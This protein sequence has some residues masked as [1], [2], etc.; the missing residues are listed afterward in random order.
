MCFRLLLGCFCAL[1][2]CA[3]E[4]ALLQATNTG[5]F[6]QIISQAKSKVY[7]TVVFIMCVR[8]N[9]EGGK[10]TTS[11]VAG[12][13]VL[14]SEKGEVL[15]NWHVVDKAIEI[16][17]LLH[18]ERSMTAKVLG[19][20]RDTDVALLQ[21]NLPANGPSLPYAKFGNSTL[22]TE[23]DFVLAM[24]A[25]WGLARSVSLGIVSCKSRYL[26]GISEYNCWL[27]TDAAIS[28]GNS[29]GPLLNTSGEIIGINTRGTM[30]GGGDTGFAI[31]IEVC[32]EV[33][34]RI[35]S[36]GQIQWSWTGLQLQ[37]LKD[38]QR[39][40][41]FSYTNGIMVAETDP[42]S[43]SRQAGILAGDR[44]LKLNDQSLTAL[45]EEDIPDIRRML[46]L[47]PK[48][49]AAKVELVRQ[50][51]NISVDLIPTDK[52]QVDNENLDC[53]RWDFTL[54]VISQFDTPNLYF[55]QTKGVY[56]NGI[57]YPG[58]A[59]AAGLQKMDILAK[60][61]GKEVSSLEE[62]KAL[63]K[64]AVEGVGQ[65]HQVLLTVMRNSMMR[66]IVLDFSRNFEK[67]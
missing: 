40:I 64:A 11:E 16:R 38:F 2:A 24:G 15:S 41:Y 7:P 67:E 56:V 19:T 3:S 25:P 32:K 30:D 47:L 37:P 22:L 20:D 65:K 6:R 28:P 4:S 53:P 45:T 10:R 50:E 62:V 46:A 18:D 52:R 44:I 35:R 58:N 8:G 43:P 57:K 14:I 33:V 63:H 17:C 1:C 26:P 66:Q 9:F 13:G 21:L 39:N 29:G 49:K 61:D 34:E 48:N 59:Q 60:I 36:D 23:G 12:S 31:P 55:Q 5:D 42:Q 54:K 51:K 27:Q